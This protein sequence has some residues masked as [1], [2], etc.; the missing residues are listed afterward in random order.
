[1]NKREIAGISIAV[2]TLLLFFI[3]NWN[4][5]LQLSSKIGIGEVINIIILFTLVLVTVVYAKRTAQMA[6]EMREQ[7]YSESLPLLVP[8][9]GH[10]ATPDIAPVIT[11]PPRSQNLDPNEVPYESLQAGIGI[12]IVWHNLGKG[13]AINS[14][15]SLWGAPLPSGKVPFFPPR[16]SQALES[17]GRKETD[18]GGW[19]EQRFEKPERYQP[20]LEAE[21]QD[22]YER[23]ITTVQKFRIEEQNNIKKAFLAELYFTVNGRRLGEEITQHD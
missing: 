12:K 1:M 9:L 15:F 6:E 14:R 3:L 11:P 5:Y 8:T 7:R 13:V 22:I 4:S 17:G 2:I 20:R 16:E 18:F 21:Y 19:D 10:L 23:K